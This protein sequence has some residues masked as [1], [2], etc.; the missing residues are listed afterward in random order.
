MTAFFSRAVRGRKYVCKFK[1][2]IIQW[3]IY[4]VAFLGRTS[5]ILSK[6]EANRNLTWFSTATTNKYQAFILDCPFVWSRSTSS[7]PAT[8][9][10][11]KQTL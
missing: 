8:R 2:L 7:A 10:Y 3:N 6:N 5:P 4:R 1:L 9:I 11:Y